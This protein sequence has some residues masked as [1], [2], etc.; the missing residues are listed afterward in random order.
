M[1]RFHPKNNFRS[2]IAIGGTAEQIKLTPEMEKLSLAAA[3][4]VKGEIVGVDLMG[5]DGDYKVIEVNGTPQFRGIAGAT[6][7][8]IAK[9]IIEHLEN[10]YK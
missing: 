1:G 8:N 3:K 10:K 4:A 2:N 9:E 5:T 6:N 7:I